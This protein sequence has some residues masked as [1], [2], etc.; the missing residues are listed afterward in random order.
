MSITRELLSGSTNGLPIK[1]A[2]SATPGTLIH[3]ATST[4]GT[5][6]EVFLWASNTS[7][8]AALLT[9]EWGGVTDPDHLLTK[10]YSIPM[11]SGPVQIAPGLPVRGG[12]VVRAFS[13]TANVLNVHGFV[14]RISQ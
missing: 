13:G 5:I 6:D 11:N 9:V 2:A 4:A 14:S 1:V 10:A 8:S 3:T 7:G 12:V